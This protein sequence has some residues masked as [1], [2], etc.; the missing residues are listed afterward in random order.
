MSKC[1]TTVSDH[2]RKSGKTFCKAFKQILKKSLLSQF[3]K[4]VENIMQYVFVLFL[5]KV[6]D[7]PNGRSPGKD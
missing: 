5:I 4:E 2:V 7:T 6:D 1:Y 3:H